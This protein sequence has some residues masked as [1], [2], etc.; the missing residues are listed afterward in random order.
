MYHWSPRWRL[1][2]IKRTGLEPGKRNIHSSEFRQPAVCTSA[3]PVIAWNYS[4]GAWKSKGTFDLWQ[5][6]LEP[7]DEVEIRNIWGDRLLEIR[8]YNRIKKAR[9]I[10]IGER[11]VT[12]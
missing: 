1:S 6:Y 4:H 12:P 9:L 11:S 2:G 7:T 3:D 5:F 8:I 10:W